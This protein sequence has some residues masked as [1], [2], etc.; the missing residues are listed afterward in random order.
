M[1]GT[2]INMFWPPPHPPSAASPPTS[3]GVRAADRL[4]Q[5]SADSSGE[6]NGEQSLLFG[7]GD[8]ADTCYTTGMPHPLTP[9]HVT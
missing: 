7:V 8:P 5:L 6:P 1:I 3:G 4:S 9:A 2:M